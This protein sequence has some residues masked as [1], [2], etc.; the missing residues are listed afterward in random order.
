[1]VNC[2]VLNGNSY[3]SEIIISFTFPPE[4]GVHPALPVFSSPC[5]LAVSRGIKNG[6][7]KHVCHI[8]CVTGEGHLRAR[9]S[10]WEECENA[11]TFY[12]QKKR[13]TKPFSESSPRIKI[14]YC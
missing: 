6:R 10:G 9:L 3:K 1:M 11:P 2:Y 7:G 8:V 13:H 12:I 4:L 5:F 14:T